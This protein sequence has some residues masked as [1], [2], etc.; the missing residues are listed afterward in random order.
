LKIRRDDQF[1]AEVGDRD[2]FEKVALQD[3]DLLRTGK[4]TTRLVHGKPPFR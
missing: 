4:M 1:I 2:F 3:S